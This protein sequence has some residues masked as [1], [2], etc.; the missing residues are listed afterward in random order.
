MTAPSRISIVETDDRL[1]ISNPSRYSIPEILISVA[2]IGLYCY[3]WGPALIAS[4]SSPDAKLNLQF[5][6]LWFFFV[7]I[8]YKC[9][10]TIAWN[11]FGIETLEITSDSLDQTVKRWPFVKSNSADPHHISKLGIMSSTFGDS[12][13]EGPDDGGV[14]H[15]QSSGKSFNF[16]RELD[17]AEAETVVEA[18]K[19][20]A[21][22][23]S[24]TVE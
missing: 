9:F 19:R 22:R 5:F 1:T 8:L 17:R 14:V 2:V 18:I 11:R 21:G 23:H 13:S 10:E 4:V 24:F 16:G 15:F 7:L 6:T 12:N 20:F 3:F